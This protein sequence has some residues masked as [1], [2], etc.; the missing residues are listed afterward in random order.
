MEKRR[1][2]NFN[3]NRMCNILP[4]SN[5]SQGHVEFM[6]S[7]VLFISALLLLFIFVNPLGK[8][9]SKLKIQENAKDLI[10]GNMSGVVG[11][12]NVIAQPSYCYNNVL[13]YG[14]NFMERDVT[15]V[16]VI[17]KKLY[18]LYFSQY[19]N[20]IHL[21]YKD[22]N[23]PGGECNVDKYILGGYVEENFI[24]KNKTINLKKSYELDYKNTKKNI[25]ISNDFSFTF[26]YLNNS[27]AIDMSV[28]KETTTNIEK[29]STE[30]PVRVIDDRANVTEMLVD[31]VIW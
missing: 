30:L 27:I 14:D 13:N 15:P 16:G 1:K 2:Y 17:N 20:N 4:I 29:F 19:V 25:G 21:N 10:I 12:L 11:K 24:I 23:N 5:R 26:K 9:E 6:I 8:S 22:N 31:I 3:K 18:E 7:F 28:N